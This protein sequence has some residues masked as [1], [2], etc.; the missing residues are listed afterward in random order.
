MKLI[1]I[2]TDHRLQ[3]S[4]RLDPVTKSWVPRDGTRFRRLVLYCIENLG[5][6]VILEEVHPKQEQVTPT[7]CSVIAKQ[8]GLRWVSLGMG[9]P[10]L[11]D[12]LLYPE[13]LAGKY[14]L[15]LHAEREV[16]M[17]ST[18]M[19][20]LHNHDC[21]LAVV[22]FMHL[23]ILARKFESDQIRVEAMNFTDPLVVDENRA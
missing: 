18:I 16:F 22:G 7:I 20:S 23:S 8:R 17:H 4:V 15:D 5:A 21:A 9:E 6:K 13:P 10:G 19:Q 14:N 12:V 3:Q 11:A 1:L 2:G